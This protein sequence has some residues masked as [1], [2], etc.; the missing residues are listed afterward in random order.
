MEEK[1]VCLPSLVS[2]FFSWLGA[3]V[4]PLDWDRPWQVKKIFFSSS[5]KSNYNNNNNP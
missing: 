3:F 1:I 4:I 5:S 2:I